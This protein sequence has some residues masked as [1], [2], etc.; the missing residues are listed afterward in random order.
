LVA[1]LDCKVPNNVLEVS[2]NLGYRDF[3]TVGILVKKLVVKD[4][5]NPV[6]LI[7]DNWIYIQDPDV[8]AG[9]LQIFN[10]W[11]PFMVKDPDTVWVG[12]EYFCKESDE[13][14]TRPDQELSALAKMEL[15]KIG[16]I[17]QADVL[18]TTVA[19]MEKAYPAYFGSYGR[20]G[21]VREYLDR[22]ENLF[23]IGRNGMHRYNNQDHSMLA[24]MTV[25]DNILACRVDKSNI[26]EV[27]TEDEYHEEKKPEEPQNSL[28]QP[29]TVPQLEHS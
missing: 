22:F 13:L 15:E 24:A 25:V 5:A 3:L 26:W 12:V 19:R 9:R 20:F 21:E 27:N 1:A 4:P 14:W 2:G 6:E 10:N 29:S 16:I 8:I 18:D 7:K 17:R 11:S 23:L 28:S